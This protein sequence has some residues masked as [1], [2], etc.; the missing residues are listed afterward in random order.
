LAPK[1]DAALIFAA[2]VGG[3]NVCAADQNSGCGFGLVLNDLN[4]TPGI[5]ELATATV[6]GLEIS[7]S[8]S[9]MTLGPPLNILDS[10]SLTVRNTTAAPVTA[11]AAVGATGFVGPVEQAFVSGSGTW[12]TA[13]DSVITLK[14]YDDPANSQGAEDPTDTPGS[15]LATFSDTAASFVDSFATGTLGPLAVNDQS[16][17]SMTMSFTLTL[18]GNGELIS[19]G[20]NLVKPDANLT[21]AIPEPASLALLGIGLLATASTLRYRRRRRNRPV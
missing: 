16:A 14:W 15:L 4:P 20:Q 3:I 9:T 17:F 6:G 21:R 8:L 11:T 2:T 7:G 12:Q 18:V 5:L 13:A 1:A 19:R 10:G